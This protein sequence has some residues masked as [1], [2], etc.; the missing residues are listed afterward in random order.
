M[1]ELQHAHDTLSQ[2]C[3]PIGLNPRSNYGAHLPIFSSFTGK[4]A[5]IEV[6]V[7]TQ[8]HQSLPGRKI[9]EA[10]FH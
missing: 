4:K 9:L 5:H 10:F 3:D 7:S 1:R 2:K 6:P 8:V